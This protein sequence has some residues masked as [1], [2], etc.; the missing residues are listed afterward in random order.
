MAICG[1]CSSFVSDGETFCG[2]C[3]K[4]ANTNS[5]TVGKDEACDLVIN[6]P[7][8]SSRHLMITPLENN[9]FEI[10]DLGSLN[11]TMVNNEK[12]Q[13]SHVGL[14]DVLQLGLHSM[15]VEQLAQM[16]SLTKTNDSQ[17]YL[18]PQNSRY[19]RCICGAVLKSGKTCEICGNRV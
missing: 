16:L 4:S 6:N 17:D 11:G 1:H 2:N 9:R 19:V 8:V 7:T 5:F 10:K 13:T 18:S 14:K 15:T 12:I 3:G